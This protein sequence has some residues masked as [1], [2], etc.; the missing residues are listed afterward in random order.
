[1]S[2][3]LVGLV[4][5]CR[6][7]ADRQAPP[8]PPPAIEVR[9]ATGAVTA[10]VVPGRPC[11]ATIGDLE[12][13]VG[14]RPLVA[15]QG[16]V[17]WTGE[18][19]ANG[20]TLFK[21]G[22]PAARYHARQLFDAEGLPLLRVLEDGSIAD[23]ASAIVRRAAVAPPAAA[24]SGSAATA[25]AVTIGNATV[26]GTTDVVLAAMLASPEAPPAVRALVACHLLLPEVR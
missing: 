7:G 11:R 20:T 25:G 10:R 23:R 8:P 14:G 5:S 3:L 9:D 17:R 21:D 12:L 15:Q 19:A 26:T 2:P 16:T 22:A 4:G 18:D 1:M 6:S 13:L 24:G